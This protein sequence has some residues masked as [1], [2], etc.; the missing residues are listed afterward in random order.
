MIDSANKRRPDDRV[1]D[2][3]EVYH[4]L[5]LARSRKSAEERVRKLGPGAK[6]WIGV[7]DESRSADQP[8]DIP[9]WYSLILK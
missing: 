7:K 2:A 4:R 1:Y 3:V 8:G 6:P 5:H 9:T